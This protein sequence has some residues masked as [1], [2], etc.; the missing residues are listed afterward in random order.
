MIDAHTIT[1]HPFQPADQAEVKALVLA[2]LVEHWGVLD[3]S[4]NPDLDDIAASYAGATFL[5]A[6]QNGRIIGT[7]AL[8]PRQEGTAEVVRMSVAAECRRKG[9]GRTLLQ[10]LVDHAQNSG[11]QRVILETTDTWQEVI[12]FY[13]SFGFHITHYQDGDVYFELMLDPPSDSQ[14]S[15]LLEFL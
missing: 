1:L 15:S 11:I 13:L 2:G 4:K 9:V 7:G 8:V 6:R 10:T 5:V 14:I 12:A 3:T